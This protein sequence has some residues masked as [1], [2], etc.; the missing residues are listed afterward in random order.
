MSAMTSHHGHACGGCGRPVERPPSW[1][2]SSCSDRWDAAIEFQTNP[3][4]AADALERAHIDAYLNQR[5]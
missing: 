5:D 3:A 2:C 4:R 1:L